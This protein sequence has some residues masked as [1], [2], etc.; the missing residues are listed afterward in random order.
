MPQG[1]V[2][3][4][5]AFSTTLQDSRSTSLGRKPQSGWN[6]LEI[7]REHVVAGKSFGVL[8]ITVA[9]ICGTFFYPKPP[10]KRTHPTEQHSV[11]K[12]EQVA[13]NT[14]PVKLSPASSSR[15]QGSGVA[16][17]ITTYRAYRDAPYGTIK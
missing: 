12:V 16:A 5:V 15:V 7:E 14:V 4:D 10:G 6:C 1:I 13:E 9:L 3:P 2:R 11:G 17:M 8:I